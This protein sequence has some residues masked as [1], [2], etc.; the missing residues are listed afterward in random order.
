MKFTSRIEANEFYAHILREAEKEHCVKDTLNRLGRRDLFFLLTR[1]LNRKDIDR[2]WLFDRCLEV[3]AN[4]DDHLDLWAREHYKSTIITFGKTIQ[5]V[6]DSHSPD[7]YGPFKEVTVGIFSHTAPIAKAF[8]SQIKMEFENNV[9]LQEVYPDVLYENP[10]KEALRWSVDKGIC[11]KRK[12]NPK[13]AT[14]A[15]HG[16]VDGQPTGMHYQ[17][18]NYDDV[19]T[20]ESVTT[21]EQIQTVTDALA[22]SYNLG[23]DGGTRR[24]IGTRYHANDTYATILKRKTATPRIYPATHDGKPEGDPVFLTRENLVKK[25][26]DMGPYVFAC[27]M[28]QN[29][30]ADEAQGFKLDW[31]RHYSVLDPSDLNLY[32]LC[33]PAGGK[34][35]DN[36]YTVML[37]IG[38][39]PDRNYYL[40]DGIR[41]RLNLTERTKHLM[42]FH[43]QYDIK[44]VGYEKYGKDSDIEHIEYVQEQERYRFDI[45]PLGG[46]MPKNDRIRKL[47]PIFETGRF[48]L[49]HRLLFSDYEKKTKDFV[50]IFIGDE[51]E[52]FPVSSHDDML[53]CMARV[54]DPELA[55]Q[56]PDPK[57]SH[58]IRDHLLQRRESAQEEYDPFANM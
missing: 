57:R 27:Q 48:Y 58:D 31:L 14:I 38:L 2:D 10:R 44:K 19:V 17:V 33:D 34:K 35:K 39:G 54:V 53:D 16:L 4:P 9:L 43:K 21:P 37:V 13:E 15:A 49:P 20:R 41:D 56:F 6:L 36:D 26:D 3:Q 52:T 55:A 28:L 29:P 46:G 42:R 5:D 50:Q 12:S 32:L 11:V 7:P 45:L 47:V 51:Y 24:F 22:L 1:L 30:V 8:L 23:A 18:L 25:R 40:V